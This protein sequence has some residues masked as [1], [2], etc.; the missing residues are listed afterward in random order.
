LNHSASQDTEADKIEKAK[1]FT[2]ITG[3]SQKLIVLFSKLCPAHN[4]RQQATDE[5]NLC[6]GGIAT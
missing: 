2:K 3:H 4:L 1:F 6:R 5:T